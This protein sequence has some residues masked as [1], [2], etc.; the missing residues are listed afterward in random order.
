MPRI[1]LHLS[2]RTTASLAGWSCLIGG[3]GLWA[4]AIL[5]PALTESDRLEADRYRMQVQLRQCLRYRQAYQTLHTALGRDDPV[6]VAAMAYH[7]LRL[8]P[9]GSRLLDGL[10]AGEAQVAGVD[11]WVSNSQPSAEPLHVAVA[12]RSWLTRMV[13]GPLRPVMIVLGG[14]CVGYGLVSADRHRR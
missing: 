14:L 8:K 10:S 9:S 3:V 6:A 11:A 13:T 2:P 7:Q 4:V 5:I 12:Q 1:P